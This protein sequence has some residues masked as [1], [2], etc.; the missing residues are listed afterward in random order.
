[1]Y[2]A[3]QT[4]DCLADT[5]YHN[6]RDLLLQV[7][8][9][10]E[11]AFK[12]L[13]DNYHSRLFQYILNLTKSKEAA[14]ELVM[15]VFTKL[16]LGRDTLTEIENIDGFLFRIAHN[17]SIDFLRS[18]ARNRNLSDFI[19]D[20]IQV[21]EHAN[22]DQLLMIKEYETKLK[23]AINLMTPARRRVYQMS[24]EQGLTHQQIAEELNVSKNTVTNQVME[25]QRF[26]RNYLLKHVDIII[27]MTVLSKFK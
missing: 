17:K 3:F 8:N 25:A 22:P 24:R 20:R 18:A 11:Q 6:D 15:D 27:I 13:F 26:I 21:P 23:E 1:M 2:I 9:G 7:A 14:E 4:L 19:W 10:N 5:D 12:A 16:W